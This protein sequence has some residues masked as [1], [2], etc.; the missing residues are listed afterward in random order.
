MNITIH[1]H[2][3]RRKSALIGGT[4]LIIMALA[5]FFSYGFVH[6]NLVLHENASATFNNLKSSIRLFK[7][8]ILGWIIILITDIIVTWAFYIFLEPLNRSLALLAAWLRLTYT[9]ILGIA[10]LN[11][12]VV[13]LLSSGTFTID[14]LQAHVMLFLE[15][16]ETIWAMDLIIFGGH[17]MVIGYIAFKSSEIPKIISILLLIAAIGYIITNLFITFFSQ[18]EEIISILKLIFNVPMVLGELGFGIWLLI[19]GGKVSK[20]ASS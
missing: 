13:L 4:A 14:Q 15:A 10:I 17:L 8:E 12:V 16:F 11:L 9:T 18:Y 3:N 19:R 6:E 7:A 2:S 5:A 20:A 1:G